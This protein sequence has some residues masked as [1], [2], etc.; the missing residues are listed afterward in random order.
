MRENIEVFPTMTELPTGCPLRVTLTTSETPHLFPTEAQLPSLLGGSVCST[1]GPPSL[2]GRQTLSRTMGGCPPRPTADLTASAHTKEGTRARSPSRRLRTRSS[3]ATVP[4]PPTRARR[5]RHCDTAPSASSSWAPSRRTSAPGCR[6]W[7][8][9]PTPTTSPTR[10]PSSA[11]SSSPSSA[12][13][14]SCPWSAACWPTRSTVSA[15]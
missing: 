5:G 11:S 13:P 9:A 7:S 14:W 15:S 12:R 6:T 3:T 4:S 1:H 8:S 10:A 2:A